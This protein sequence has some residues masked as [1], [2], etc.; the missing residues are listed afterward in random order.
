MC[1]I[2]RVVQALETAQ[3]SRYT[4]IAEQNRI[5]CSATRRFVENNHT[6]VVE[7][8]VAY[9]E[10]NDTLPTEVSVLGVKS[11]VYVSSAER[12]SINI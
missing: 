3:A 10:L 5:F 12:R 9:F 6:T 1:A 7:L 4:K 8:I 2:E 11:Q